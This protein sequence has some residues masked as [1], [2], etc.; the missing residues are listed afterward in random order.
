M[1]LD[2]VEVSLGKVFEYGQAYVALSR[3][4]SLDGLRLT[5]PIEAQ[6]VRAHPD[7]L[8]F[9]AGVTGASTVS[10]E[11]INGVLN[12]RGPIDASEGRAQTR[13][14]LSDVTRMSNSV[15]V[16]APSAVCAVTALVRP[17]A[18]A[19]LP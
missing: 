15:C 5:E 18:H 2:L 7:V 6:H 12:S 16:V 4:R 14:P 17:V 8:A 1:T 10:G 11:R 19:A 13:T 9:F 3:A